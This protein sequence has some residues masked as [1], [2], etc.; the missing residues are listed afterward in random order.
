[1]SFGGITG[2]SVTVTISSNSSNSFFTFKLGNTSKKSF[3]KIKSPFQPENLSENHSCLSVISASSEAPD[4]MFQAADLQEPS[5]W[6]RRLWSTGN[7]YTAGIPISAS[8]GFP[9][10]VYHAPHYSYLN[11][12]RNILYHSLYLIC[13]TNQINLS[14]ATGRTGN[15]LYPAF[16]QSKGFQDSLCRFNFLQRRSCQRYTKWY[17]LFPDTE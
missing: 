8:L 10:T 6:S 7:S 12:Q 16:T 15:Y 9:W 14:S 13:K 1:M 4:A 17:L 5:L 3:S 2:N 11:I